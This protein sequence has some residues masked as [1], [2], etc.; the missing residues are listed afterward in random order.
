MPAKSDPNPK[1]VNPIKFS[2]FKAEVF[3]LA[4][5]FLVATFYGLLNWQTPPA[6]ISQLIAQIADMANGLGDSSAT[7]IFSVIFIKNTIAIITVII[8]GI[9]FGISPLISAILNGLIIGIVVGRVIATDGLLVIMAGL[10]PHGI[11]ELP[12]LFLALG[13]GFRMGILLI[14]SFRNKSKESIGWYQNLNNKLRSLLGE[15]KRSLLFAWRYLIPALALA[16]LIESTATIAL[17]DYVIN[18]L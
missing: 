6:I 17:V 1:K 16:A 13:L 11:I 8:G 4:A 2:E 7:E 3:I 14:N 5:I 12:A 9:L 15:L 10:I 18:Y